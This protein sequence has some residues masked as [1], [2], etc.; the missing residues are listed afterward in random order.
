MS[1]KGEKRG[2]QVSNKKQKQ[3][4]IQPLFWQVTVTIA[5]EEMVR[6]RYLRDQRGLK[7]FRPRSK[8]AIGEADRFMEEFWIWARYR[9]YLSGEGS[10]VMNKW[11]RGDYL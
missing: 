7:K 10:A 1:D 4:T 5:A 3:T 2:R 11:R 8:D 6:V 9:G